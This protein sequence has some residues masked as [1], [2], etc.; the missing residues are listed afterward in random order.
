VVVCPLSA[1]MKK[2]IYE[3]VGK[4][5]GSRDG[6]CK[7]GGETAVWTVNKP[8]EKGSLGQKE[9]RGGRSSRGAE[10]G[11]EGRNRKKRR[12]QN[13]PKGNFAKCPRPQ[14]KK[15]IRGNNTGHN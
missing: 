9:K 3:N 6:P 1:K 14:E 4:E 2:G 11:K 12:G 10:G 8:F 15:K 7:K 5:R 13:A